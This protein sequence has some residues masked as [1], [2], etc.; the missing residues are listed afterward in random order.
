MDQAVR[1]ANFP[2]VGFSPRLDHLGKIRC[3]EDV[4]PD[5]LDHEAS[6]FSTL[7]DDMDDPIHWIATRPRPVINNKHF[8]RSGGESTYH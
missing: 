3:R 5:S 4:L 8:F 1:G 6:L 2:C 7:I